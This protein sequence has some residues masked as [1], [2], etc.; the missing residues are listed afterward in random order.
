MNLQQGFNKVARATATMAGSP[1]ATA[2]AVAS[3]LVWVALGPR[4]HYSEN[5][6]LVIN[7]GTTIITFLMVFLIQHTQNRDSLE[8]HVKLNELIRSVDA[9]R[10]EVIAL[11]EL[12]DE[13]LAQLQDELKTLADKYDVPF[14][15]GDP[16]W[17]RLVDRR[18]S[19]RRR[20]DHATA[21]PEPPAR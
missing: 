16:A 21:Q 7:T 6:Q 10:N 5:W 1:W 11:D 18:V 4:F 2:L 12:S 14:L 20:E 9:A 19:G 13:A 8:L 15:G 17:R 3:V